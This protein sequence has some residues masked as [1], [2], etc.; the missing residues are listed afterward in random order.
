VLGVPKY[1]LSIVLLT[2]RQNM[3][4]DARGYF[5]DVGPLDAGVASA[6]VAGAEADAS[7]VAARSEALT[8]GASVRVVAPAAGIPWAAEAVLDSLSADTMFLRHVS[9]PPA[10]RDAP[11]VA[12]PLASIRRLEVPRVGVPTRVDRAVKGGF[13][14]LG[15]YTALAAAVVVYEHA[16]CKG[17]D[18][19]GEG[20]WWI[21]LIG[22]LPS[23]AG[24]GAAVGF[25][26]P[27][28]RWRSVPVPVRP[29]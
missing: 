15:V 13:W 29:P 24:V 27:I 28:N 5:P 21:G 14:G 12:L 18:C 7:S 20:M 22:G 3:G 17:P 16:A 8:P 1:G 10:M 9:E 23:A 4:T 19:F 26:L 11:R 6:I 25:A 2:N